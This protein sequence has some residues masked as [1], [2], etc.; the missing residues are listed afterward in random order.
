MERRRALLEMITFAN[1]ALRFLLELCALASLGYWGFQTGSGWLVKWALGI[2]A[3]LLAAIVWGLFVSPKAT[4]DIGDP[5][6]LAVEIAVFGAAA[7]GLF[8]SGQTKL[9][10]IFIAAAVIN[11]IG[12]FI[13]KS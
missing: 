4:Y 9:C 13:F 6:R 1:L 12:L 7:V 5:A 3:P 8:V 2:G 11:R 10:I